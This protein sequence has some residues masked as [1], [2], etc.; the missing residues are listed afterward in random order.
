[1][2]LMEQQKPFYQYE[3]VLEQALPAIDHLRNNQIADSTSANE[4]HK[5]WNPATV[6]NKFMDISHAQPKSGDQSIGE[7]KQ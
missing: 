2:M 4:A 6:D 5:Y 3:V 7:W 1:M